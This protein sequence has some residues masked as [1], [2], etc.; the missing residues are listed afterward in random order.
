MTTNNQNIVDRLNKLIAVAEDGKQGYENASEEIKDT[1]IL[2][3]FM[4]FAKDRALYANQLRKL[5]YELNGESEYSSGDTAGLLHRVWM[6]LKSVFTNGD[7]ESIIKACI[8]GEEAA[9]KEYKEALEDLSLQEVHTKLIAEQLQGIQQ[10][11]AHIKSH[12]QG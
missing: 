7:A 10:T 6:D 4:L 8:T 1:V 2:N 11:L 5:V 3:S 12:I 9:V